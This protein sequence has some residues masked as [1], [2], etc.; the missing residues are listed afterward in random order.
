MIL[1]IDQAIVNFKE[2]KNFI[3]I[4]KV[5]TRVSKLANNSNLS[6][7]ILSTNNII[8]T[9]LFEKDCEF[10]VFDFVR[11]LEKFFL[12]GYCNYLESNLFETNI[13]TIENLFDNEKGVLIMSDDSKIRNNRLNLLFN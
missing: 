2:N 3:E 9:K 1:K 8:D 12:T 13:N 4:Q 11:E 6:T 7:D 5:I 10:K